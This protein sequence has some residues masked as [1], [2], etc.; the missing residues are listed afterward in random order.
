VS[1][2]RGLRG[3]DP[4]IGFRAASAFCYESVPPS[5]KNETLVVDE[6]LRR[7]EPT[8]ARLRWV[9]T[10]FGARAGRSAIVKGYQTPARDLAVRRARWAG[11]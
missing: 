3:L 9:V 2:S 8:A 10:R 11:V 4:I 6:S 7:P 1:S 5:G